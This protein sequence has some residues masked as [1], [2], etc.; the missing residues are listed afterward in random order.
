MK[1]VWDIF[2]TNLYFASH[3]FGIKVHA[4]I[5]MSN[6]YHMLVSAPQCNLSKAIGY[7]QKSCTNEI[8]LRTGNI[9]QLWGGRFGRSQIDSHK[10]LETA[11]K[12]IYRNPV[13]AGICSSVEDYEW[14]SLQFVLGRQRYEFP[15]YDDLVDEI[16]S[17]AELVWLN[18]DPG[19]IKRQ[20]VRR[21]LR[22]TK[23]Q[24]PKINQRTNPI[25]NEGF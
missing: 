18:Q 3:C 16:T 4:F 23:F 13:D 22:R 2:S 7:F 15:V 1:T 10:Y 5:L 6:H 9:N 12:Y 24:L 25:D 20:S 17:K 19:E 14:S 21:A 8:N 11:Y